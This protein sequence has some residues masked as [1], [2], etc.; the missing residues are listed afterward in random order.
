MFKLC[1]DESVDESSNLEAGKKFNASA[2]NLRLAHLTAILLCWL[3]K[4][5]CFLMWCN[6]STNFFFQKEKQLLTDWCALKCKI[7]GTISACYFPGILILSE[8]VTWKTKV[9]LNFVSDT[10]VMLRQRALMSDDKCMLPDIE[11]A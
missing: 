9:K 11:S 10:V 3:H 4:Q 6:Y 8:Q 1:T 2:T 7:Y 5:A